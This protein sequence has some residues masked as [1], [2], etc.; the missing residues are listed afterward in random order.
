M[1]SV[2]SIFNSPQRRLRRG[3]F[4]RFLIA[5][6]VLATMASCRQRNNA[7]EGTR[8]P[9]LGDFGEGSGANVGADVQ[10]LSLT[11]PTPCVTQTASTGDPQTQRMRDAMTLPFLKR[12]CGK[13]PE[14]SKPWR[15]AARGPGSPSG[16]RADKYNPDSWIAD[17]N[18]TG[19]SGFGGPRGIAVTSRH[20]LCTSHG[21]YFPRVGQSVYFLTQDN[22]VVSRKVVATSV[23]L[24]KKQ[25]EIDITVIR[26]ESDLPE[27]VTPFKLL[28]LGGNALIQPYTPAL[29][30]DTEEKAL[31]AAV[32]DNGFMGVVEDPARNPGGAAMAMFREGMVLYDSSSPSFLLFESDNGVVPILISMVAIAGSGDGPMLYNYMNEIQAAIQAFGDPHQLTTML[33]GPDAP[34]CSITGVQLGATGLCQFSITP[35]STARV[36]REP[37]LL[38]TAVKSWSEYGPKRFTGVA[39]CPLDGAQ[40]FFTSQLTSIVGVGPKCVSPAFS[41]FPVLPGCS[42]TASR[43]G[44]SE[45]CNVIVTPIAGVVSGNP[46]MTPPPN[47]VWQKDG[48]Q[49]K[50][51]TVCPISTSTKISATLSGPIGTGPAC[52]VTVAAPNPSEIPVCQ[53]SASRV[54]YSDQCDVQVSLISGVSS[55]NPVVTPAVSADWS[56]N[57]A[58]YLSRG[59]CPTNAVTRFSASIPGPAGAWPSCLSADVP[60]IPADVPTCRITATRKGYT[61]KCTIDVTLVS[62]KTAGDPSLTPAAVDPWSLVGSNYSTSSICPI[63]ATTAFTAEL[64]GMNGQGS[65]CS[66]NAVP[67]IPPEAPI[68]SVTAMRIPGTQQCDVVVNLIAGTSTGYPTLGPGPLVP[69]AFSGNSYR[70]KASCP[71]GTVTRYIASLPGPAGN[72][73]ACNSADVPPE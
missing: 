72:G 51:T 31:I 41:E 62:G 1:I 32:T 36:N 60:A 17:I 13:D 34:S 47:S 56:V 12:I 53:I 16:W 38:P 63:A 26:L 68:C 64:P 20:L 45:I 33:R 9:S 29:R 46:L 19:L 57:G 2:F 7:D 28:G 65:P 43:I 66:S 18:L 4:S 37:L 44:Y 14:K 8:K 61:R 48:S 11:G 67:P 52:S 3:P 54:G 22:V 27:S 30:I 49:L 10:S 40:K 25:T 69:W 58:A 6:I 55:G 5:G 35:G 70:T 21:G 73:P 42:V 24:D 15:S 23:L 71:L 39:A 59:T 50:T